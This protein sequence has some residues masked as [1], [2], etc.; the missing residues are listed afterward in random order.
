M[1]K[2]Y[3]LGNSIFYLKSIFKYDW[4]R[5]PGIILTAL[6]VAFDT[7][8]IKV[9]AIKVILD[10]L[11]NDFDFR[12]MM[13]MVAIVIG[14]KTIKLAYDSAW[15]YYVKRSDPIIISG[16]QHVAFKKAN[17]VDINCYDDTDYY[18]QYIYSLEE[19]STRPIHFLDSLFQ[20]CQTIFSITFSGIFILTSDPLI[21]LF[22]AIPI[23]GDSFVRTRMIK[24]RME[25]T[26]AIIP[27]KRKMD[28]VLRTSYLRDNA[29]DIRITNIHVVLKDLFL[30]GVENIIEL[31]KK[32]S[33]RFTKL[34]LVSD[35]FT[36]INNTL[37]LLYLIY[38]I[39]VTQTLS[40]GDFIAIK[41]AVALMSS[42]LGKIMERIQAFQEHNIY[43]ERF[44]AFCNYRNK[45]TDGNSGIPQG[46]L[47]PYLLQLT[48]VS[49]SYNNQSDVLNNINI[50]I[51]AGQKIAI[52]G[53]NGAGKSTLIK[54]MMRLYDATKGSIEFKGT[55]IKTFNRQEYL[56]QFDTVF[57]DHNSYACSLIENILFESNPTAEEIDKMMDILDNIDFSLFVKDKSKIELELTKEF[58]EEGIILSGGQNQKV[59]LARALYRDHSV[60]ILDEPSSAL[61]SISEYKWMQWMDKAAMNRTVI[62]ISHRLSSVRDSDCIYYME[63]GRILEAGPH[64]ELMNLQG[65]Y[66]QMFKVQAD[67]Y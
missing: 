42:N 64:N 22:V 18:N 63:A 27:E 50:A 43:I 1:S 8:F 3:S 53:K 62:V 35:A 2:K 58:S 51:K 36:H 45:V 5:I 21:L 25:R 59:A 29:L 34:Y 41:E 60:L 39:V 11:M 15:A 30:E 67:A 38:K 37:I 32:F 48:N 33:N 40:A 17:E 4:I 54:L 55:D 66:F 7:W 57:Q 10:A 26:H 20:L 56:S 65:H 46:N 6:M 24:A 12:R 47:S 23:L 16:F 19:S 49:F 28:Y 14:C 13:I 61:D 31:Y 9:Y 52:V 44:R